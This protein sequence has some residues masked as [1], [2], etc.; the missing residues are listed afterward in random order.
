MDKKVINKNEELRF[1]LAREACE[2][3]KEREELLNSI[4]EN[5]IVNINV[6]ETGDIFLEDEFFGDKVYKLENISEID[7]DR[8]NGDAFKLILYERENIELYYGRMPINSWIEKIGYNHY[9]EKRT[10]EIYNLL[11]EIENKVG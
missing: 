6:T 10:E 2:L 11:K 3:I 7:R 8:V 9:A 4:I 5:T 1:E